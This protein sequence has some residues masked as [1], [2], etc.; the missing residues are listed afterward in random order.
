LSQTAIAERLLVTGASVTSLVDTLERKKLV[1][2]TRDRDDRRVVLVELTDA[3]RP[4][5]DEFLAEVTRL[6]AAEFAVLSEDERETFVL[7][8]AKVAGSIQ[9]LDVEKVVSTAKPRR[10]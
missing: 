4:V 8:L 3:A 6:H 10:R 9:S 5:I 1:T 7:L 2:R